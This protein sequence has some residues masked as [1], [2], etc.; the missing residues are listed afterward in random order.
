MNQKVTSFFGEVT[1]ALQKQP[2]EVFYKKDVLK[3]FENS[4]ENTRVG[5]PTKRHSLIYVKYNNGGRINQRS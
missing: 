3:N 1:G 2:P 4:Q 5:V